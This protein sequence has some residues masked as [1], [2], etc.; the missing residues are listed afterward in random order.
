MRPRHVVFATV[1]AAVLAAAG[2][3]GAAPGPGGG[4]PGA[5][6]DGAPPDSALSLVR[7]AALAVARYPSASAARAGESAAR[8]TVDEEE[9]DRLP[10]LLLSGSAVRY[11]E[12]MIARPIH[13]FTP[14]TAPPFDETLLQGRASLRYTLF[15][16]GARGSRIRASRSRAAAAGAAR[17]AAEDRLVVAVAST[18]VDVLGRGE[19]L[20]AHDRRLRALR[21][22][23]DRVRRLLEVGRIAPVDSLRIEA[24]LAS[25]RA[26]KVA[27][28]SSLEVAERELARLTGLP[29]DSTREEHLREVAL[30][31][32]AIPTRDELVRRAVAANPGVREVREELAAAEAGAGAA[33]SAYWP[34]LELAGDWTAWG[35]AEHSTVDEWNA[36]VR[37][38]FPLFTGGARGRAVA[39]ADARRDGAR[40]AVR[41]AELEAGRAVDR[42]L[43]ALDEARARVAALEVAA[44]RSR[45]VADAEALRLEAGRGTQ[46]DY[47][48]A[49]ADLLATRAALIRARYGEIAA[50]ISLA[51]A[52]GSLDPG[53]LEENVGA[54]R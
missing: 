21:S 26:E 3:A 11:E 28:A 38:S 35:S 27:V 22:E 47:L 8:A 7:A 10:S 23:R 20:R 33:R 32:P 45:E 31:A 48:D 42:A 29:A 9:A 24:S 39:R 15:D 52:T 19:L 17:M 40:D 34:R 49:E 16:G 53:W 25:A 50:R 1:A 30:A 18:Y 12:P 5:D 6:G 14:G 4:P 44:A 51:R 43:S 37:V 41:L 13:G 54:D 36:G 46:T 2:P